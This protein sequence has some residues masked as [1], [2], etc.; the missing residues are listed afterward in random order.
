M[1][2]QAV[3]I[4]P[5]PC[6]TYHPSLRQVN[7]FCFVLFLFWPKTCYVNEADLKFPSISRFSLPLKCHRAQLK[8]LCENAYVCVC[9]LVCLRVGT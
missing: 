1:C 6:S 7:L 8:S 9:V 2:R 3:P 4:K 5:R